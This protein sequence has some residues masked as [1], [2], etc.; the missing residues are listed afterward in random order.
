ME[1][2]YTLVELLAVI[3]IIAIIASISTVN[4]IKTIQNAKKDS[5]KDSVFAVNNYSIEDY[6]Q[7]ADG[8]VICKGNNYLMLKKNKNRNNVFQRFDVTE[9]LRNFVESKKKFIS[10]RNISVLFLSNLI[11]YRGGLDKLYLIDEDSILDGCKNLESL[12]AITS[13]ALWKD[14]LPNLAIKRL[15]GV[16]DLVKNQEIIPKIDNVVDI[17]IKETFILPANKK[18]YRFGL[19]QNDGNEI[20]KYEAVVRHY[21]FPLKEDVECKLEMTYTYGSAQPYQLFFKP[22]NSSNAEFTEAKVE[23]KEKQKNNETVNN[24]APEYPESASW[25]ELQNYPNKEGQGTHNL[26]SFV[27]KYY[28]DA[29]E[30][31][32]V[33][34]DLLKCSC[35]PM[36]PQGVMYVARGMLNGHRVVITIDEKF[37][38]FFNSKSSF[39]KLNCTLKELKD[40]RYHVSD[41][42]WFINK[43]NDWM[44]VCSVE[45]D[46]EYNNVMLY[47]N[48]FVDQRE[49]DYSVSEFTFSVR[50]KK[51]NQY[52]ADNIIPGV[53]SPS[54]Y[55]AVVMKKHYNEVAIARSSVLFALHTIFSNGRTTESFG[56]PEK[57]KQIVTELYVKL[58]SVYDS[59]GKV[60]VRIGDS[61][62]E[63]DAQYTAFK[64]LALLSSSKL[65]GFYSKV[66]TLLSK[67]NKHE[68]ESKALPRELGY[69]LGDCSNSDQIEIFNMIMAMSEQYI[70]IEI[71]SKAMWKN[72]NLVLNVPSISMLQLYDSAIDILTMRKKDDFSKEKKKQILVCLEFI[73][74]ILRMRLKND[75]NINYHLSLTKII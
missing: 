63:L 59:L 56:C 13:K 23:W 7:E 40:K 5:F 53:R 38:E 34:F 27:Q 58:D 68:L 18:E 8:M 22:V 31:G 36:Y 19:Q 47:P 42:K 33:D 65:S 48:N 26:L 14:H 4:I 52:V 70:K 2:G 20:M 41:V 16:F 67:F 75:K 73:L 32:V 37:E 49:F 30:L 29:F 15:I 21:A 1:K 55:S 3:V 35:K 66:K 12:S 43:K 60:K 28:S 17:E 71:L 9:Q 61:V 39:G 57:F 54:F 44:A 50:K 10:K 64:I 6:E 74:A 24:L 45:I 46:N 62:K 11:E 51:N 72:E 25:V 69:I